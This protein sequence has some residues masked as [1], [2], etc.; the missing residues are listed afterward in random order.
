MRERRDLARQ[1]YTQQRV[2]DAME[3]GE[4]VG[5]GAREVRGTAAARGS[6]SGAARVIMGEHEFDKIQ[7]GDVLICPTTSPAWSILFTK[8]GA[9][10]TDS[11]GILSNPA[12]IAREYGIPAV[13]A[14]GNGT[15]IIRDG[16]RVTVDGDRGVVRMLA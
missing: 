9:L 15:E 13:V 16:Q 3:S 7:Q 12:I 11:G 8:A 1:R 14:T 2:L 6:Y 10:V 5:A 4:R